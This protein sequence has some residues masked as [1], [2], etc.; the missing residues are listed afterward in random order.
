ML[1]T[2]AMPSTPQLASFRA[3]LMQ[4][5][6]LQGQGGDRLARDHIAAAL[7]V[8]MSVARQ[9]AENAVGHGRSVSEALDVAIAQL[10]RIR[11]SLAR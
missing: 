5:R 11:D 8:A 3:F 2:I 6:R 10:E 7:G 1:Q 9:E 4:A